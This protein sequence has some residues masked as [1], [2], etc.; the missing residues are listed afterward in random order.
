MLGLPTY[1]R[2]TVCFIGEKFHYLY[3][4]GRVM[5]QNKVRT[6]DRRAENVE[7][8]EPPLLVDAGE[9]TERTRGG[10]DKYREASIG[11]FL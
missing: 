8:Y 4:R 9:F 2:G 10:T 7:S 3:G 1:T 11:R 6:S 5:E